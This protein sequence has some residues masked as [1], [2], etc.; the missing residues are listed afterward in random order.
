M[1]NVVSGNPRQISS[2][3]SGRARGVDARA[4]MGA[5]L[6]PPQL[7]AEAGAGLEPDTA[8]PVGCVH[9]LATVGLHPTQLD[10][11]RGGAD[12]DGVLAGLHLARLEVDRR[13][14][15]RWPTRRTGPSL[16][17]SPSSVDQAPGSGVQ[18]RMRRSTATAGSVQSTWASST[19]IFGAKLTPSA[20]CSRASRV[21][22]SMPSRVCTSR[23]APPSA[24]RCSRSPAVSP[25]RMV[26][27]HQ[28]VRRTGVELLDDPERGRPAHLVAGPDGVLHRGGTTP[29]GQHREVQVHPAVHRDVQRRL[30]EQGAVGDHRAAV[31]TE[32]AQRRL[33]VGVARVPRLEHG[34]AELLGAHADRGGHQP[35]ATAGRGVGTG[36]HAHQLVPAGRDRLERRDGDV[37][38]A[39]EDDPHGPRARGRWWRAGRSSPGESAGR[40]TRPRG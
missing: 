18:A 28:A 6:L 23:P 30:R 22:S 35:A 31:G 2:T 39:G 26:C 29:G 34:Y 27:G 20:G 4:A 21:P 37:G 12:E 17:R 9:L 33:E 14:P 5:T 8:G 25:G 1:P 13:D 32:L 38:G 3:S 36:D 7:L 40:T 19:V 16:I 11:R 24:R 10:G 15:A